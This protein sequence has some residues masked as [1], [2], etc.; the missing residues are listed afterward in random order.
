MKIIQV[1]GNSNS[2]KTTFIKNLIPELKKIGN[3]AVIKHLGDHTYHIEEGKDTTIFFEA[4]ADISIGIDSQKAVVTM[5]K[6]TLEDI[7]GMLFEQGMDFVVIEGFK[8]RSFPKIV[9]GSLSADRCI[10]TNPAV[11][12]V[13]TSLNLFENFSR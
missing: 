9:I 12:E 5:R 10:L 4:G 1:V 7:F 8:K 3:V 13:I 2:G 11:S 6:N